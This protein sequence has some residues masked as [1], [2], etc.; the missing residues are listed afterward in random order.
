MAVPGEASLEFIKAAGL[1]S[2][3]P[4]AIMFLAQVTEV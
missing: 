3:T 2:S 1:H 4:S